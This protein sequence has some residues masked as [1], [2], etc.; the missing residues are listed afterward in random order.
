MIGVT[1]KVGNFKL[2]GDLR[3]ILTL[4][5]K[6]QDLDEFSPP[7]LSGMKVECQINLAEILTQNLYP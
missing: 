5:S 1:G 4:P 6:N 2:C 7:F 3:V